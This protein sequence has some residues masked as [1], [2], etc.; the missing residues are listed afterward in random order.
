MRGAGPKS[1]SGKASGSKRRRK[2]SAEPSA[3]PSWQQ[4]GWAEAWREGSDSHPPL[5]ARLDKQSAVHRHEEAAGVL[6]PAVLGHAGRH[7]PRPLAA[8]RLL[9]GEA[10]LLARALAWSDHQR[11]A[12]RLPVVDVE[13]ARQ[14][15][16]LDAAEVGHVPVVRRELHHAGPLSARPRDRCH[17]LKGEDGCGRELWHERGLRLDPD[18]HRPPDG[19]EKRSWQAALHAVC[20]EL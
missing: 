1:T 18:G 9:L 16:G 12:A 10:L 15:G 2:L 7:D 13:L 3:T 14:A 4:R 11:R 20:R 6:R 17:L 19:D 5:E 8:Q